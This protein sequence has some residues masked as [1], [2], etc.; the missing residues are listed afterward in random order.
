MFQI[1]RGNGDT[2]GIVIYIFPSKR[3]L[4]PIHFSLN[5]YNRPS[6]SLLRLS[7]ITNRL[8]RR[9]NQIIVLT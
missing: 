3:I 9:E 2:L 8:S 7:Q 1:R 4:R 5:Y 6:L